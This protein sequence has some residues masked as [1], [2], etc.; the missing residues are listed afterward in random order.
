MS[1][2]SGRT[3]QFPSLIGYREYAFLGKLGTASEQSIRVLVAS[4]LRP[5][6]DVTRVFNS[7]RADYRLATRESPIS[8]QVIC[9]VRDFPAIYR[10]PVFVCQELSPTGL[11]LEWCLDSTRFGAT[12]RGAQTPVSIPIRGP[13]PKAPTKQPKSGAYSAPKTRARSGGLV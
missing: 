4:H 2:A 7:Y 5:S 8:L 9:F 3:K 6:N 10:V 13:S 11:P 12:N 1:D